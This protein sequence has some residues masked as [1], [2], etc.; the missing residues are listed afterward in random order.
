MIVE[1]LGDRLRG[2][3]GEGSVL[4]D[5]A[6]RQPF[7]IEERG[8]YQGQAKIVLLPRGTEEVS[9]M[10]AICAQAGVS[11]VPQGGNTGLVGGAV[12][13][14]EQAILSLR[15]MNRII[16]IDSENLTMTV[17]AGAV[18]ANVRQVAEDAGCLFP[19]YLGSAGSCQIGGN[20]ASN[21][22]G[23]GVLRYGNMRDLVLGLE[24]VLPDGRVWNG[25]RA[26]HKDNT[27]YAL[28]HVFIGSEGTL[29]VI[30]K[31]VL[32]L[33]KQPLGTA[34]ALCGLG[35]VKHALQLLSVA[36]KHAAAAVSAFELISHQSFEMVCAHM[37][38]T[39]PI[40]GRHPWY[41]LMELSGGQ[42][43]SAMRATI[44]AILGD[45][46]EGGFV[47][48]AIVPGSIAQSQALWKLREHIPEAEK[49]MGGAVKHDIA[50]PL[51]KLDLFLH[52][53]GQVLAQRLPGVRIS[54]FGH[55]GDGNIHYNLLRP[56]RMGAG[57]AS[58]WNAELS[59]LIYSMVAEMG[60]SISA[61]HGIGK[62]KF[63]L[64]KRFKDPIEIE[65][66]QRMKQIFD[67]QG[68]LNPGKV[69]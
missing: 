53:A 36:R 57:H 31:A 40:Q 34:T 10:V 65:L 54:A 64:L 15:R 68:M 12:A 26:L 56:E 39:P 1:D 7:L 58:D 19:M 42:D 44:E 48:D 20:I 47:A 28:R 43:D 61:E 11:V 6:D 46:L 4:T 24:I 69:I 13:A 52:Q 41:V 51:S 8:L 9:S 38:I 17:E 16:D 5:Q 2:L 37:R 29:G 22:G 50:L 60:G 27:G 66:M 21:A 49:A 32:K 62:L 3:F 14:A 67:P 30:T 59:A 33:F 63:D 25:L 55:L 23:I 18:L 35:S 45:G